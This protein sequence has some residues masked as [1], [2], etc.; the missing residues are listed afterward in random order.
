MST[1]TDLA[2]HNAAVARWGLDA[3]CPDDVLIQAYGDGTAEYKRA[4]RRVVDECS[5]LTSGRWMATHG[6]ADNEKSCAEC[7]GPCV[8]RD[9]E[10]AKRW[11][12]RQFC[13]PD[14]ATLARARTMT[15]KP[16]RRAA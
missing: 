10:S 5:G 2:V 4:F 14:C 1:P 15:G 12:E 9:G 16:R 3:P 6:S 8:R 11:F 13:C 7:G